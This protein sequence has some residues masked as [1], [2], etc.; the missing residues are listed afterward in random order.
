MGNA[1]EVICEPSLRWTS[2]TRLGLGPK[3]TR[4]RRSQGVRLGPSCPVV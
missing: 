1:S 3:R 2:Q 4:C